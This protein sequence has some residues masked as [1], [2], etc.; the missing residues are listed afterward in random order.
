MWEVEIGTDGEAM[1]SRNMFE[2]KIDPIVNGISNI[3]AFKPVD[4][5]R[6]EKPTVVMLSNVQFIKGVKIAIQAADIIINQLGFED[7]QLVVYG[8]KHRQPTYA[9]E[10]EKLIAETG[11]AGKVALAGF[12]NPRVVL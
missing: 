8:A 3:D 10:I 1:G 5:V 9:L 2:G 11:L 6:T 7:Y 4:K 12:G